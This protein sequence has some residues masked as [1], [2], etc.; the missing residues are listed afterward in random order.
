MFFHELLSGENPF[1]GE[2]ITTIIYKILNTTPKP[3]AFETQTQSQELQPIV[4]KCLAKDPDD[5]YADFAAVLRH[6]EPIMARL[7]Q[8]IV[9][10]PRALNKPIVATPSASEETI[11]AP[12]SPADETMTTARAR[13]EPDEYV[14]RFTYYDHSLAV[15]ARSS[16]ALKGL[17]R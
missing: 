3:I 12:A 11:V 17:L 2:H 4:S 6:L 9:P 8:T 13:P 15:S 10:A 16:S 7:T 1:M 14:S 5:R